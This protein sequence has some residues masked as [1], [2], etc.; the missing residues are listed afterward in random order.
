MH[1][2]SSQLCLT[3]SLDPVSVE[4]DPL[5][6][7]PAILHLEVLYGFG[8]QS[9]NRSADCARPVL[10]HDLIASKVL[11]AGLVVAAHQ[12]NHSV[13]A[14]AVLMEGVDSTDHGGDF[15]DDWTQFVADPRNTTY[16]CADL[17]QDFSHDGLEIPTEVD[18]SSENALASDLDLLNAEPLQVPVDLRSAVPSRD[19]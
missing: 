8:H 18:S 15:L 12:A 11:G 10:V 3:A 2:L 13:A 14:S 5:W 19:E 9:P 4:D 16:L 6:T 1:F 17:D 7:D